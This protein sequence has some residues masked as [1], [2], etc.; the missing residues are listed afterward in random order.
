[1][2]TSKES[3]IGASPWD[4][5]QAI[6]T[7]QFSGDT[8]GLAEGYLQGNVVVLPAE[9]ATDFLRFCQRNPKPCPLIGVSE[10]GDPFL[11]N[12]GHD[13]DIRS[14]VPKY[15][16]FKHGEYTDQV[17][18]IQDIWRDDLVTFVLGCSFSFEDALISD[19]VPIRYIDQGKNVSMYKTNIQ[20][21]SAGPFQ[22][23]IVVSMRPFTV[24]DAIR[25]IEI[26]SR[27]PYAHGAPIHFGNPDQIG[28][29]DINNPEFGDATEIKENEIPVF[30][31]CGVTPQ[32]AIQ[33]AKPEI[34]I[35]HAPGHMLITDLRSSEV[36]T[37]V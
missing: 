30:W 28:I 35:T 16:I 17:T 22:G 11:P 19:G 18:Q 32:V 33:N 36:G 25:A 4:V 31:A 6:R 34:T 20:T 5:R 24:P 9:L 27:F 23:E 14:D 21:K 7:T 29:N 13:I 8:T 12:L 37:K 26:T 1:M 15:K 3:L 2:S 10:T